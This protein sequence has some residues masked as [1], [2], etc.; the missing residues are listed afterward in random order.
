MLATEPM[1]MEDKQ[2]VEPSTYFNKLSLSPIDEFQFC[3]TQ[4]S[5]MFISGQKRGTIIHQ[6][7]NESLKQGWKTNNWQMCIHWGKNL[8]KTLLHDTRYSSTHELT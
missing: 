1:G 8:K 4:S 2:W 5:A 6:I 7:T 3:N